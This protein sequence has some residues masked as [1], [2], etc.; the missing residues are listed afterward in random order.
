[1]FCEVR[2]E[3]AAERG[4]EHGGWATLVTARAAIEARVM[5]TDRMRPLRVQGRVVHQ[6][7]AALPLGRAAGS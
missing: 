7:G 5:V 2:P 6:V 1:M 4:L 3:L